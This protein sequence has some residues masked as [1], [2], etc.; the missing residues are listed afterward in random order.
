MQVHGFPKV[1][2]VLTHLDSFKDNKRLKKTKKVL[3][4]RFWAEIYQGRASRTLPS[5]H[6]LI[7]DEILSVGAAPS[8]SSTGGA[9]G[10]GQLL[11]LL[12]LQSSMEAECMPRVAARL[13]TAWS[14]LLLAGAGL[15]RL[16]FHCRFQAL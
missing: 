10:F 6:V 3:K 13:A 2:G 7:E 12:H 8:R 15:F 9:S 1:M 16:G 5:S 11:P 14:V 4:H